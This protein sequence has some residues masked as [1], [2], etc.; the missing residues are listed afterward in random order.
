MS[1]SDVRTP[2]GNPADAEQ[3]NTDTAIIQPTA[4]TLIAR[5]TLAGHRVIKGNNGDFDVVHKK[6]GMSRY[7]PDLESLK[8]F[9]CMLGIL[10]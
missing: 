2:G 3:Q 8:L 10:I 4:A 1:A 6:F 5:L 9:T 7:C